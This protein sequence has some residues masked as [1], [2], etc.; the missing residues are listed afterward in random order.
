MSVSHSPVLQSVV[1]EACA[2]VCVTQPCPPGAG[3]V[4]HLLRDFC[5]QGLRKGALLRPA[6]WHHARLLRALHTARQVCSCFCINFLL[7]LLL[8]LLLSLT[9]KLGQALPSE[10]CYPKVTQTL[11]TAPALGVDILSQPAIQGLAYFL[12][13]TRMII[14][15][16]ESSPPLRVDPKLWENLPSKPSV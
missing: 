11:A 8:L 1:C 16:L 13:L 14:C 9:Y 3:S 2:H 4:P 7:L 10:L 6:P 5:S 12:D 15:E